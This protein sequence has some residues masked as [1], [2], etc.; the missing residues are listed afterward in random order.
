MTTLPDKPRSF[1]AALLFSPDERRL[2]AGWRLALQALLQIL[3]TVG[4]AFAVLLLPQGLR[5]QALDARTALGLGLG[6]IA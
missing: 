1:L 4:L 5:N 2:R 3:L 6:E